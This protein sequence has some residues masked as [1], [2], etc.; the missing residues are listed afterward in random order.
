[1]NTFLFPNLGY[2]DA[3]AAI[4]FLV[5]AF[6][7]EE[8]AVY[9]GEKEGTVGHAELRW[10]AGGGITLHTAER[11]SVADLTARAGADGGYPAYSVHV[12]TD[13][14][15]ALFERA[16][17]AGATVVRGVTDAP[18]GTRGFVVSDPEGLYWSFGTSLPRLVRDE[19]G[20]WRPAASERTTTA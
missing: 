12:G 16:V 11:S 4:D 7:F 14:P 8:V 15:D 5:A 20:K 18:L 1:M 3:R 17:A 13:E 10:P 19:H 6:G 9:E 2:R